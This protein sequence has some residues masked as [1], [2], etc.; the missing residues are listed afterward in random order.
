MHFFLARSPILIILRCYR[1]TL[2]LFLYHLSLS[3]S[4]LVLA[5]VPSCLQV[6]DFFLITFK[7]FTFH[8]LF[9]HL[10]VQLLASHL[11]YSYLIATSV[12]SFEL[13][14]FYL[15]VILVLTVFSL[16]LVHVALCYSE[17]YIMKSWLSSYSYD[18][19]IFWHQR[20]PIELKDDVFL[21]PYRNSW[22]WSIND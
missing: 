6:L 11:T 2:I 9:F 10:I 15:K 4:S 18:R 8:G 22:Y 17:D 14:N 3:K 12:S 5:G 16:P 7:V 1:Q 21:R 20:K 13:L 19:I